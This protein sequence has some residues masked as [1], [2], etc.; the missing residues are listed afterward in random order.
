[1]KYVRLLKAS[2]VIGN[3]IPVL[4]AMISGIKKG[5]IPIGSLS[6]KA[7][8]TRVRQPHAT[9]VRQYFATTVSNK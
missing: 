2:L 5:G 4:I 1:M 8:A 6:F 3:S 9:R 7:H